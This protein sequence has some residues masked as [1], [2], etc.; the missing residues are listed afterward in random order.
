M[1]DGSPHAPFAF[2]LPPFVFLRQTVAGYHLPSPDRG[3][4]SDGSVT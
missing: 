3:R 1:G 2:L 4:Y